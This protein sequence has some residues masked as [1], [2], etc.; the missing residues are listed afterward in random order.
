MLI[1]DWR[2]HKSRLCAPRAP[3]SIPT[4]G[5]QRNILAQNPFGDKVSIFILL[6]CNLNNLSCRKSL[7]RFIFTTKVVTAL[8]DATRAQQKARWRNIALYRSTLICLFWFRRTFLFKL[9]YVV[10]SIVQVYRV[11]I[12]LATLSVQR[13]AFIRNWCRIST[14]KRERVRIVSVGNRRT[15]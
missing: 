3:G 4:G 13:G 9:R 12:C 14:S 1:L 11:F 7:Y 5:E 10:H 8:A 15:V 2:W 6:N